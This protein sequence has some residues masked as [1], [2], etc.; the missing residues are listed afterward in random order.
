MAINGESIYEIEKRI[1]NYQNECDG[2]SESFTVPGNVVVL[3]CDGWDIANIDGVGGHAL[4]KL[5]I[6]DDGESFKKN[7]T[8]MKDPTIVGIILDGVTAIT[9]IAMLL[10]L[11]GI[12][13]YDFFKWSTEKIAGWLL[14]ISPGADYSAK[15][16]QITIDTYKMKIYSQRIQTIN[17]RLS[18]LDERIDSLYWKVGLLDLWNLMKSDFNIS[19][20]YRLSRCVSYLSDTATEFENVETAIIKNL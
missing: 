6:N 16:P 9:D 3:E 7:R 14:S 5:V 17:N 4:K 18:K 11:P 13:I 19:W 12:V 15:N 1:T 2:V 20:S 8:G 10:V